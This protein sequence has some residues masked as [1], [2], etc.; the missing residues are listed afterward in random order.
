MILTEAIYELTKKL[1]QSEQYG[2][3]SQMQRSAVSIPS[4][5]AEGSRRSTKND[6]CQF[7][8]I[9]SGSTAELETQLIVV[10]SVYKIDTTTIIEQLVEIQKMIAVLIKKLKS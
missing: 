10:Q 1:P 3:S 9:A 4:N 6:F 5:I 2:L 7:L 8:R